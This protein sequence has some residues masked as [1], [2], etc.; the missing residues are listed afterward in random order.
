MHEA[1]QLPAFLSYALGLA[2]QFKYPLIVIGTVVEGP[3]LMVAAG[4]LYRL[5]FFDLLPLFLALMVGDLIGDVLWYGIG[6]YFADPFI[7]KFGRF[8]GITPELFEKGKT[9]FQRHDVKILIISKIT[10][11]FGMA[12]GTLMAAGASRVPIRTYLSLNA[13][14]EVFLVGGLLA[15]GYFFGHVYTLVSAGFR[16]VFLVVIAVL[17]ILLIHNFSKYMRRRINS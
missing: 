1:I 3:V 12:L 9:F 6:Y 2:A 4:F 8:F 5:E 13:G 14:G 15:V 10:L 16:A 11:G 7:S 17:V